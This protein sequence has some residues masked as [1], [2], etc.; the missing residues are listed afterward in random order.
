MGSA[1]GAQGSASSSG[2]PS[3]T[4]AVA[5]SIKNTFVHF[6]DEEREDQPDAAVA[7][8]PLGPSLDII[9]DTISPERLEAYRT[10]YQKF[11]AGHASGAKGE[12]STLAALDLSE[13][14][15]EEQA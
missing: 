11:R 15:G 8:K 5:Y 3:A 10:D 12:V 6:E 9:P 14:A 2:A 1:E 13:A 7:A 4:P